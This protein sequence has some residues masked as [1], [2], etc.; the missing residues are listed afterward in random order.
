MPAERDVRP[1]TAY[2]NSVG[3]P[4]ALSGAEPTARTESRGEM[5]GH[6]ASP[7]GAKIPSAAAVRRRHGI[8]TSLVR[9]CDNRRSWVARMPSHRRHW[10]RARRTYRRLSPASAHQRQKSRD[11]KSG[12]QHSP[13]VR[14]TPQCNDARTR[15][16]WR[17]T[18]KLPPKGYEPV[19]RV[20]V[21]VALPVRPRAVNVKVPELT[22]P[23]RDAV[24][25]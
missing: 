1:I 14:G 6:P 8:S 15:L 7:A 12:G 9:S 22:V 16:H 25:I 19:I 23:V 21:N 5:T 3:G 18:A 10:E 13:D 24:L 4:G 11:G 2:P 20:A 17:F